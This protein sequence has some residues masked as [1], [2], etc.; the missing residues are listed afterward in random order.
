MIDAH[1]HGV[2]QVPDGYVDFRELSCM[3]SCVAKVEEWDRQAAIQDPRMV[4]SYGVHPWYVED[5]T[6]ENRKRLFDLLGEDPHAQVGEIGLDSKR[7]K[8]LGQTMVMIQQIDIAE[9]Y[10]RVVSIH[11]VGCEKMVLDALHGRNLGGVILHSYGSDSYIKPYSERGCYFS[12]SP[13]ILSRSDIRVKRLLDSIPDDLLLLETDSP[14]CGKEFS[15][16]RDFAQRLGAVIGRQPEELL[17][18]AE[19]NLRRLFP[20]LG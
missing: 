1:L 11:D 20:W 7:G 2:E 5:W 19:E 17:S 3:V 13:R 9:H 18:L 15:G 16:M 6:F 4:K 8:V 14:S 10:G 12:I